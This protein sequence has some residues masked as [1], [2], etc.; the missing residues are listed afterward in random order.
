MD[1]VKATNRNGHSGRFNKKIKPGFEELKRLW[2]EAEK[3]MA[4]PW[5]NMRN[6]ARE[7]WNDMF[8]TPIEIFEKL[9]KK[10]PWLM[11]MLPSWMNPKMEMEEI[12]G[13]GLPKKH[14]GGS[15]VGP[16]IIRNDEY[17]VLPPSNGAGGQ[18]MTPQQAAGGADQKPVTL[19]LNIDGREFVR[20][21]VFPAI[22]KEFN[23]QG[24]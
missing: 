12:P 17:V 16:A 21:T 5:I 11:K 20:Q 18:V 14:G 7:A 8:K 13:E 15:L 23:L 4:N 19:V 24:A 1:R 2:K 9:E 6:K 22:N 3:F 10:A